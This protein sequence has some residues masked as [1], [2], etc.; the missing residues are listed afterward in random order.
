MGQIISYDTNQENGSKVKAENKRTQ[1]SN[2]LNFHRKKL[3]A[4]VNVETPRQDASNRKQGD[5]LKDTSLHKRL[6]SFKMEK[7]DR[8][9]QYKSSYALAKNP[10]ETHENT[11][12]TDNDATQ[13]SVRRRSQSMRRTSSSRANINGKLFQIQ[14]QDYGDDEDAL[15]NTTSLQNTGKSTIPINKPGASTF[16]TPTEQFTQTIRIIKQKSTV[17]ISELAEDKNDNLY[18]KESEEF[19][20]KYCAIDFQTMVQYVEHCQV[21]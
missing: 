20:C 10:P 12:E 2:L 9:S 1:P 4:K 16:S 17:N 13:P 8:V 7:K 3:T 6:D 15:M 21:I 18:A 5:I 14:T 11:V 19:F